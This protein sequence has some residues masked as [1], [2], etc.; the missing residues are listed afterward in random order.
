[1]RWSG[2]ESVVAAI[3]FAAIGAGYGTRVRLG[4][5]VVA[6][7]GGFGFTV[8]FPGLRMA[9][10]AL[11]PALLAPGLPAGHDAA[12]G[13]CRGLI[14]L[15]IPAPAGRRRACDQTFA[16][17][18]LK[19]KKNR[20]SAHISRFA[21]YSRNSPPYRLSSGNRYVSAVGSASSGIREPGAP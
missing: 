2:P 17:E 7:G 11:A 16:D 3:I 1:M 14:F 10:R 15:A 12:A 13:R 20:F 5:T 9:S 21:P 4:E 6:V 18:G 19:S 8:G